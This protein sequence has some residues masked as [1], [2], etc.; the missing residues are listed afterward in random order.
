VSPPVAL[1]LIAGL[2][3]AHVPRAAGAEARQGALQQEISGLE[4]SPVSFSV[5]SPPQGGSPQRFRLGL[6]GTIRFGRHSWAK[7]YWTPVAAGL[8][9]AGDDFQEVVVARVQTEGGIVW[10]LDAGAVEI[11]MAAGPGLLAITSASSGCGGSCNI[12]GTGLLLSPVVR[13]LFIATP[14]FTLGAVVRADLPAIRSSPNCLADCAG[15]AMLVLGGLDLGFGW[16]GSG[17]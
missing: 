14:A 15:R 9:L 5:G 7:A 17:R 1:A 3:L 10:R 2:A 13:Y 8:F 4:L 11:G 6:G 12:G 16:P